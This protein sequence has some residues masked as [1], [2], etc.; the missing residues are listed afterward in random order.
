MANVNEIAEQV[1]SF[2]VG[3]LS[4]DD[5]ENW[6]AEYSWNIHQRADDETQK[7]AYLVHSKIADFAGGLLDEPSLRREMAS[8]VR[9]FALS[10]R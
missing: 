5:L 2:L 4:F 8:A 7:L 3:K 10:R 9:P 6:S 1:N